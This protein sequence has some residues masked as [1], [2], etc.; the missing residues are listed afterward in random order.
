MN[1]KETLSSSDVISPNL[2][3]KDIIIN[4]LKEYNKINRK[5]DLSLDNISSCDN[6]DDELTAQIKLF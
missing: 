6:K 4:Y 1:Y 2:S 3:Q 5:I